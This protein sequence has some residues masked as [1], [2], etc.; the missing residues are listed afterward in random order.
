MGGCTEGR[1]RGGQV[2]I[3]VHSNQLQA[4]VKAYVNVQYSCI[5]PSLYIARYS[6]STFTP[7][8]FRSAIPKVGTPISN[9]VPDYCNTY[10]QPH[11]VSTYLVPGVQVYIHTSPPSHTVLLP[12][13]IYVLPCQVQYVYLA[14][15]YT[16]QD[17]GGRSWNYSRRMNV[18]MYI[19]I[20]TYASTH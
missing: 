15:V 5:V 9:L 19:Y 1:E 8:A 6:V 16:Y 13:Y 7:A 10:T 14:Y 11:S 12:I 4:R 3:Y 17:Q 20:N 18:R 2:A